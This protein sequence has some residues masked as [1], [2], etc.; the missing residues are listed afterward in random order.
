MILLFAHAPAYVTQPPSPST[1]LV[2]QRLPWF[3]PLCVCTNAPC[4]PQTL[5]FQCCPTPVLLKSQI[6]AS[7]FLLMPWSQPPLPL[8]LMFAAE[9][10]SDS[11]A[12]V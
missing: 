9:G 3:L 1:E 6:F 12:E 4:A 2:G 10:G 11:G 8:N 7:V 5:C